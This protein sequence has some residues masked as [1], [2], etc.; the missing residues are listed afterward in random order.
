MVITVTT[1][2]FIILD[3]PVIINIVIIIIIIIIDYY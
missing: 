3:R 1:N 2:I